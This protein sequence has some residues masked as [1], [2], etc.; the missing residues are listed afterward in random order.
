MWFAG[1]FRHVTACQVGDERRAQVVSSD[2]EKQSPKPVGHQ[3]R[4]LSAPAAHRRRRPVLQ[5]RLGGGSQSVASRHVTP[6]RRRTNV[7]DGEGR[8]CLELARALTSRVS[9]FDDDVFDVV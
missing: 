6:R 8:R 3:S 7:V 5:D 1:A 9:C 4:S 2:E